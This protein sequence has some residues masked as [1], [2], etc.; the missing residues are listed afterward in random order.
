MLRL[1]SPHSAV[2][3][4]GPPIEM[5]I[6]ITIGA[7]VAAGAVML[8]VA[9]DRST[10]D[11]PD[12]SQSELCA[13]SSVIADEVKRARRMI[14]WR[15]SGRSDERHVRLRRYFSVQY[16]AQHGDAKVRTASSMDTDTPLI[17][18]T[19]VNEVAV[20][21]YESIYRSK[22]WSRLS[23]VRAI[24][25]SSQQSRCT[26][27]GTQLTSD[28]LNVTEVKFSCVTIS[29][30]NVVDDILNS[31][32]CNQI[33]ISITAKLLSGDTFTKTISH[34]YVQQYHSLWR[35]QDDLTRGFRGT[36]HE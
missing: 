12:A 25:G 20:D 8:I 18:D 23:S 11:D 33:N 22:K 7:I 13:L 9:I 21:N 24:Y 1:H 16:F 29:A 26:T 27:D 2:A 5:M 6:S 15:P 32:S 31:A 30:G 3:G 10:G 34:T 28:Q 35:G 14:L 19:A 17:S 36:G 4:E